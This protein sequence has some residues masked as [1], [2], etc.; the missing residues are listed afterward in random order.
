MAGRRL[1]LDPRVR[2][3]SVDSPHALASP[4]SRGFLRK[5]GAHFFKSALQSPE[6]S[7]PATTAPDL[8]RNRRNVEPTANAVRAEKDFEINGK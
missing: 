7:S 5:T 3:D 6:V 2:D 4:I 1:G 8:R